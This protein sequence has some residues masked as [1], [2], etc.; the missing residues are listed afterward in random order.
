MATRSGITQWHHAT[1]SKPHGQLVIVL[2]H[3]SKFEEQK[4]Q[5]YR[6]VVLS[7]HAIDVLF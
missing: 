4:Q 6:V 5:A 3:Q 7:A 1:T 2:E